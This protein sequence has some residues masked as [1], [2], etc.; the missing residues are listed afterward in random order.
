MAYSSYDLRNLYIMMII[1]T[2][3]GLVALGTAEGSQYLQDYGYLRAAV[4]NGVQIEKFLMENDKNWDRDRHC[5]WVILTPK[6]GEYHC[7]SNME[8]FQNIFC[9]SFQCGNFWK[10]IYDPRRE[11]SYRRRP[12]RPI[13]EF[14]M[15]LH[16][17]IRSKS[18]RVGKSTGSRKKHQICQR[19]V[20][21]D[22]DVKSCLGHIQRDQGFL[23]CHGFRA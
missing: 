13:C 4:D 6:E 9:R 23:S 16:C 21:N 7:T 5:D 2:L 10:D 20:G 22:G 18:R 11:T 1:H 12:N 17:N 8:I 14:G 15:P 19:K 3:I